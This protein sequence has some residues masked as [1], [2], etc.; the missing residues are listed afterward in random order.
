[1]TKV[2]LEGYIFSLCTQA[3]EARGVRAHTRTQ[4]EGTS[5]FHQHLLGLRA[6]KE[7]VMLFTAGA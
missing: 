7:R 1:M 2:I 6:T 4:A 3:G 5:Y